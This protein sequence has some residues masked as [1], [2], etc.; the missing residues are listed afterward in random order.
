MES[1]T[2]LD[3][4]IAS[5]TDAENHPEEIDR[6]IQNVTSLRHSKAQAAKFRSLEPMPDIET[7]MQEWPPEFEQL[8]S[9]K[10]LHTV[11]FSLS[12]EEYAD[13]VCAVFDVPVYEEFNNNQHFK[14][15]TNREGT[16]NHDLH[17]ESSAI[18][19]TLIL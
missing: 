9:K 10:K 7:L 13:F 3:E 5:I 6:W 8:L 2:E 1:V 18:P 14:A 19:D 11:G 4:N 17:A 16:E 12:L 15:M